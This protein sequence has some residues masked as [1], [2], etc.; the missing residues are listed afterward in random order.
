MNDDDENFDHVFAW[1]ARMQRDPNALEKINT[2]ENIVREVVA[3]QRL[4]GIE[5]KQE[6]ID[7]M[8]RSAEATA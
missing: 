7:A 2:R 3:S 4:S 5:V 1:L 8:R 6:W